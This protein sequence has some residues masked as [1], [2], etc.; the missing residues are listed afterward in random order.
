MKHFC[1][2]FSKPQTVLWPSRPEVVG[3]VLESEEKIANK[4]I[5][6]DNKIIF[7]FLGNF[8]SWQSNFKKTNLFIQFN[9]QSNL[10]AR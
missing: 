10:L 7:I 8:H 1:I 9:F 4:P 2:D 5:F 3:Q 6:H